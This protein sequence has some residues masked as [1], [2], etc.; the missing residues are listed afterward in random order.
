MIHIVPLLQICNAGLKLM[1]KDCSIREIE[2]YKDKV[3]GLGASFSEQ[4]DLQGATF[5][6][7]LYS[8]AEHKHVKALDN[9]QVTCCNSSSCLATTI[10]QLPG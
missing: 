7:V 2:E 5:A 10:I 8:M 3:S 9:L 1:L 6:Y 4:D